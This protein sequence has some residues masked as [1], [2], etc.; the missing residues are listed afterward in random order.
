MFIPGFFVSRVYFFLILG[1]LIGLGDLNPRALNTCRNCHTASCRGVREAPSNRM[2]RSTAHS[3]NQAATRHP[4]GK[5]S[6]KRA[7]WA[8][9]L[10][11]GEL[12]PVP[13]AFLA[14]S[15]AELHK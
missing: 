9:Q 6:A 10:S 7:R 11:S 8:P 5:R 2:E 3:V 12:S 1:V 14:G 4:R 13:D 15:N